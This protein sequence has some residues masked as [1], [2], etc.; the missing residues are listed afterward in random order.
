MHNVTGDHRSRESRWSRHLAILG[1]SK[2]HLLLES[3]A[4]AETAWVRSKSRVR[5]TTARSSEN[6]NLSNI[7][8]Y[9]RS[10]L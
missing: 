7:N 8:Q 1:T 4:I 9:L 3:A 5:L 6:A 2:A 10:R